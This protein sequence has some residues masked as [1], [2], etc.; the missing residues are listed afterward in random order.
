MQEKIH[1]IIRFRPSNKRERK[2][3][4]KSNLDNNSKQI[5]FQNNDERGIG[6]IEIYG[7]KSNE[8]KRFTFDRI[9]E[10]DTSQEE[11]FTH[12][13]ARVCNDVIAGFNGCIFAYGQTGS[14]KTY[15]MFGPENNESD[16]HA[17]GIIPRSVSYILSEIKS[18][19]NIL[20]S[21]ICVSFIEIYK[22]KLRDLLDPHSKKQ[23]QIRLN[24]NK[25]T[26][27]VNMTETFDLCCVCY[28][29]L[30]VFSVCVHLR[31]Y[32]LR[33]YILFLYTVTESLSVPDRKK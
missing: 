10:D 15:T 33:V 6:A 5:L 1:V 26:R 19:E 32:I 22:E 27:V 11:T 18:D 17:M 9:L 25:E 8:P 29:I 14:G 20:E 30:F 28:A 24:K 13:A 23:L 12:V 2:E 3:E 31:F 7:R 16:P 4:K 21:R